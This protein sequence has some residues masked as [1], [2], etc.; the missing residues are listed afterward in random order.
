MVDDYFADK[1][2]VTKNDF[3]TIW[4]KVIEKWGVGDIGADWEYFPETWKDVQT[5]T[6]IG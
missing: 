3:K 4:S 2:D 1:D 6:L 5:G